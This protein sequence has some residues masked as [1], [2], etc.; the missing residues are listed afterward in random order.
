MN[1]RLTLIKETEPF[2]SKWGKK[3]KKWLF[4]CTC[5]KEKILTLSDVFRVDGTLSC[6]C[7]SMERRHE[8]FKHGMLWTKIYDIWSGMK[9]RCNKKGS[10]MYRWYWARWIKV[11][12]RWME[13]VNFWEDMKN[14]YRDGLSIDRIDNN[15]NYEPWNCRWVTRSENAVLAQSE[16]KIDGGNIICKRWHK[17][18]YFESWARKVK[19][20]LRCVKTN[21][22]RKKIIWETR[23]ELNLLKLSLTN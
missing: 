2:I 12:D 9:K 3:L 18:M 17:N 13:F 22:L 15:W 8:K 10:Q 5:G 21:F 1:S 7:L 19:T 16:Y 14:E 20:C 23:L 11:C 4:K 6:W